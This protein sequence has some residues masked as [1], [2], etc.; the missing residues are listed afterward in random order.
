MASKC[1]D[2]S[3]VLADLEPRAPRHPVRMRVAYHDACHLQHGQRI[4]AQPRAVL[5]TIPELE[6]VEV[7]EGSLCCGSAG[8]FNLVEPEP[9]RELG[10]RKAGHILGTGADAVASGNPGCLLQIRRALDQAGR[11]LPTLHLVDLVDASIRG[12]MPFPGPT[13]SEST[14][15]RS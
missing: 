11:P 14:P 15:T 6:L 4:S 9:A 1:R 7:P 12:V 13:R 5:R 8:I 2:I 3:E 10:E